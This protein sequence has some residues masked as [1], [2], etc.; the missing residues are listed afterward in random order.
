MKEIKVL[1]PESGWKLKARR[2][3]DRVELGLYW[4]NKISPTHI[5]AIGIDDLVALLDWGGSL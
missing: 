4:G 2:I 1:F 5:A 3:A